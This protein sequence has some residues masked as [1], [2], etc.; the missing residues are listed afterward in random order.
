MEEWRQLDVLAV[1]TAVVL[2]LNV[3]G[4]VFKVM[5]HEEAVYTVL[6]VALITGMGGLLVGYY[7]ALRKIYRAL[8]KNDRNE[9]T[10]RLERNSSR[11]CAAKSRT[12]SLC[13]SV[14]SARSM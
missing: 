13:M 3:A 1:A 4:A 9:P 5:P 11:A 10:G 6:Y 2:A 14:P 7:Y 8:R 12:S